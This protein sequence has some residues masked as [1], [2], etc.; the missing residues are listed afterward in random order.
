MKAIFSIFRY[1]YTLI[2][3][4]P[5][6]IVVSRPNIVLSEQTLHQWKAYL[7]SFQI[8]Y[9][10]QFQKIDPYDWFCGLRSQMTIILT[11]FLQF[12]ARQLGAAHVLMFCPEYKQLSESQ[13]GL[14]SFGKNSVF[15]LHLNLAAFGA[16]LT[17]GSFFQLQTAL[18]LIVSSC[19]E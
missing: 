8:M 2:L 12:S 7:F 18:Y 3:Q 11:G 15:S 10:S 9:K 4:N 1:F 14:G 5:F 13:I 17:S 6:Q 19:L 16:H